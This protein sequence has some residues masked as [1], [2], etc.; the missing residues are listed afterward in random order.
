M[1]TNLT[2]S[3]A[4][5]P[6]YRPIFLAVSIWRHHPAIARYRRAMVDDGGGGGGGD[7]GG[8]GGGGDDGGGGGAGDRVMW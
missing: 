2:E 4:L 6:G 8:G 5:P 7:D 1:L 3:K